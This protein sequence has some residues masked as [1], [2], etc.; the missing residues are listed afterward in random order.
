M[1]GCEELKALTMTCRSSCSAPL[2][3]QVPSVRLTLCRTLCAVTAPPENIS[4]DAAST[5][6]APLLM[7][8]SFF[9]TLASPFLLIDFDTFCSVCVRRPHACDGIH[10]LSQCVA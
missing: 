7:R 9:G 6:A 3:A 8:V 5:A 10:L 1:P 2:E 4:I